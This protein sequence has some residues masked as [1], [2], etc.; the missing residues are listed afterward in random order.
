MLENRQHPPYTVPACC[1]YTSLNSVHEHRVWECVLLCETIM[2]YMAVLTTH[3]HAVRRAHFVTVTSGTHAYGKLLAIFSQ[4]RLARVFIALLSDCAA[5][6]NE[7][8][9]VCEALAWRLSML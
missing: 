6:P 5:F 4:E 2:R 8:I 3:R 1:E 9:I 7:P